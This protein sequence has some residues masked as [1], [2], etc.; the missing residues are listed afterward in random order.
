MFN[1]ILVVCLGNI[2][3][4]PVGEALIKD[5]FQKTGQVNK[6][7]SSAG[8]TAMVDYPASENSV[9][10]MQAKGI[11]ISQHRAR[12]ITPEII[13]ENDLILVMDHDQ[14]TEL[15]TI[16]PYS[17]GKVQTIGRFRSRCVADPYRQPL[18]AFER[19]TENLIECVDDRTTKFWTTKNEET[20]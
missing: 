9:T 2:C 10:V 16:F 11:D 12:Q 1:S 18:D 14:K 7:V 8:I 6:T 3:R 20:V 5:F 13:K 4:S 15:E 17:R 19:M